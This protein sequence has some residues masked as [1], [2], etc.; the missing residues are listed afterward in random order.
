MPKAI[1]VTR[2]ERPAL[3]RSSTSP[4]SAREE[5]IGHA[6]RAIVEASNEG[7]AQVGASP[8]K[9]EALPARK[10]PRQSPQTQRYAPEPVYEPRVAR[11][12]QTKGGQKQVAPA[13]TR[14]STRRW[15][16]EAMKEALKRLTPA[17]DKGRL[18]VYSI[19]SLAIPS[20]FHYTAPGTELGSRG[21]IE[22]RRYGP[23]PDCCSGK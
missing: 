22:I 6:V 7:A 15:P 1:T 12:V 18:I 14:R 2:T 19:L 10:S 13:W 21:Y 3:R 8:S 11:S 23:V 5:A 17:T 4:Q 9:P 16:D 20:T